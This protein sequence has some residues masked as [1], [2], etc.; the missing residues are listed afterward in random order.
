[1]EPLDSLEE[2]LSAGLAGPF[3]S[4]SLS[5]PDLEGVEPLLLLLFLRLILSSICVI[6]RSRR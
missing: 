4:F 3:L 1:M 5:L 2:R 6:L